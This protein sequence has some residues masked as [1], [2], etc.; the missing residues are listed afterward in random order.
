MLWYLD[1]F[2]SSFLRK[3]SAIQAQRDLRNA[4]MSFF[5]KPQ[6][7]FRNITA[8]CDCVFYNF[9]ASIPS[10]SLLPVEP[11]PL[12]STAT[13]PDISRRN[14]SHGIVRDSETWAGQGMQGRDRHGSGWCARGEGRVQSK[15][16]A[17]PCSIHT[18]AATLTDADIKVHGIQLCIVWFDVV[19][20]N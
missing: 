15:V 3:T 5:F 7:Q 4:E 18:A 16:Y 1:T 13:V 11:P 14:R 6:W 20:F 9:E 12:A 10:S 17:E 8:S 19:V 2:C